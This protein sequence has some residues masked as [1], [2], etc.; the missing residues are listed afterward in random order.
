MAIATLY[1]GRCL[2]CYVPLVR[3]GLN[4][5]IPGYCAPCH[6]KWEAVP[7]FNH[8]YAWS[9]INEVSYLRTLSLAQQAAT[10]QARMTCL[11]GAQAGPSQTTWLYLLACGTTS[12]EETP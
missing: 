10:V 6:A 3:E 12:T 11:C 7:L 4:S 5:A 9:L 2:C 1:W 8:Q